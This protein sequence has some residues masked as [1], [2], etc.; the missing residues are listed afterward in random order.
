VIEQSISNA[1][2]SSCWL[3]IEYVNLNDKTTKYWIA[4]KDID[5]HRRSFFV[6]AFNLSKIENET[7]GLIEIWISFDK[8]TS[9]YVVENTTYI[10]PENLI[11]KILINI[12][13][14]EW[15]KYDSY[16]DEILDYI[17][18][19]MK[20]EEVAYQKETTLIKGIDQDKLE[21][22]PSETKYTL[23]LEQLSDLV[24]KLERLSKQ[25]ETHK[26]ESIT[27]AL[28]YL[29]I[30]TKNGLFVVAYRELR[31]NP[32]EKALILS[33]DTMFNYDFASYELKDFRHNLRNYLDFET[34]DFTELFTTNPKEAKDKLAIEVTRYKESLDDRP[35]VFELRR[36]YYGHIEKEIN[37]IKTYKAQE[38]LSIPLE[39]FFGNMSN[40][41]IKRNRHVDVVIMDDKANIDQL[42]VIY[43]ALVQPITYVQGP[44]GTGKTATIINVLISAF[45]NNQTVLVSSN[46]NK[47]ITDIYNKIQSLKSRDRQIPLPF[48]RIGNSDE[49]IKS[50]NYLK[51]LLPRYRNLQNDDSKLDVH[52]TNK[53][54]K[55]KQINELLKRY[56]NHMDLEEEI[57]ALKSLK[58]Q[59]HA[60]FRSDIIISTLLDEK[61]KLIAAEPHVQESDIR[62]LL[63]KVDQTFLTW[64][65]FTSVK[66]IKRLFEP[67]NE[68]L[69][70]IIQSDD[71]EQ[72]VKDFN[73]LTL[74]DESFKSLQRVFPIILTTNQSSYKLGSQQQNFDLVILDEAGQCSIGPSLFPISRGERLLLVGDQNQLKPVL[75]LAHETNKVLLKK[76]RITQAYDYLNNSILLTMQ[77]MDS[78]SKFV[79]L[80]YHYRSRK[81]I[82]GFSN[83][84]YYHGQL[85]LPIEDLITTPSLEFIDIDTSRSTKQSE[86]NISPLEITEI[87]ESIKKSKET[88]IGVITPFRNQAAML[89]DALSMEGYPHIDVGTIHT[90]QGDEK[91]II[92]L[93]SG[94]T[95]HSHD[96]TFDWVKNNQE[97]INVATTRAKKRLVLATD[98]KEIEKRSK[99]NNDFYELTQY[100]KNKGKEVILSESTQTK[101]INGANFKNYNTKKENE[102][103]ETI[104]HLLSLGSKYVVKSKVRVASILDNFTSPVKHDYGLKSE[105]DLVVFKKINNLEIPVLV[106]ELDGDE[107]SIDPQ[108]IRRDK[109]KEEICKD[110]NIKIIHIQNDYSRRYMYIKEVFVTILQ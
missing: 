69:L 56:E 97:L 88:N 108:V 100:V 1:I 76:Y 22:L 45:F 104:N 79:L 16:N 9:A 84:K 62:E 105:F 60:G 90:F 92:Y 78:I 53:K 46:N 80:S 27:L 86:K 85:K 66:H 61:E 21:A 94:L 14:L 38:Q 28:N 2:K 67:K 15:L 68:G 31:F 110:N 70:A 81:D 87:I 5:V 8:I 35:Y 74:N 6:N 83:A 96:K 71:D 77:K 106:I 11:P 63:T 49:I 102:F 24:P 18:E 52:A 75:S 41:K 29:S 37:Q 109:L 73:N 99:I 13:Q 32:L 82:I 42:R 64:L 44:P 93:S 51:E 36:S 25:N 33:Q 59:I 95:K 40:D 54:E 50:L 101:F 4:I 72:R 23:S 91:D 34:D 26:Y 47:P 19:C 20:H 43:N 107:H 103:F 57:D 55:M 17:H 3:S 12:S 39:A 48:L 30:S 7:Q 58:K 10:Q 65:F 89:K 98:F